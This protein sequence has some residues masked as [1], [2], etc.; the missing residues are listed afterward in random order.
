MRNL[1]GF[2]RSVTIVTELLPLLVTFCYHGNR[3]GKRQLPLLQRYNKRC[4][5]LS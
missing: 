3:K 2:F 5:L 1:F 4:C